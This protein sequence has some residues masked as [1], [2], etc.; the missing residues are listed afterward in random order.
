MVSGIIF[1]CTQNAY[2][3]IDSGSMHSFVSLAFSK[4]LTRPLEPM[5]CLLFMSIPF[6]G[7]MICAYICPACDIMIGDMTLYVDLLPLSI[8]HFDCILGMD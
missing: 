3:L 6:G 1:I 5:N 7:S 2:V 8:N 4:K